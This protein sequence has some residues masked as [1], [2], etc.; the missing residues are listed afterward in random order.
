M[1]NIAEGCDTQTK[2]EFIMFLGYA[3][4]S[5]AETRSHFYY[6]FDEGYLSDIEFSDAGN[7]TKKIG[8]QLAKL[9]QYLKNA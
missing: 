6:G 5:S 7:R 1:A 8:A 9:I 4:R 3:K 2:P